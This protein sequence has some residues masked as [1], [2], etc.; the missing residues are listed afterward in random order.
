M[1]ILAIGNS[2][3]QDEL[4][5]LH[6][7]SKSAGKDVTAVNLYIGGCSLETHMTN[8]KNNVPLYEY[9]ENGFWMGEYVSIDEALKREDWDIVFT[10]Q[11]SALSGIEWTYRPYLKQLIEHI[12]KLA[13]KAKIYLDETWAYEYDSDHEGFAIYQRDQKLMRQRVKDTYEKIAKE[14]GLPLIP[15]GSALEAVRRL[16]DFDYEHG[17][18][19]LHRDGFHM[20]LVYGRYLMGCVMYERLVGGNILD[21]PYIPYDPEFGPANADLIDT[22]KYTVHGFMQLYDK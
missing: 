3:S 2:F 8:I 21:A 1:K 7:I 20:H 15:C 16:P 4:T 14:Y 9:Q 22:I 5:F 17:G 10:H 11:A 19:S 6:Q 13:P 18:I 12:K